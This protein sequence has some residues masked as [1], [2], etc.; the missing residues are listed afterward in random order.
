[1]ESY[2]AILFIVII[3]IVLAYML[4]PSGPK[5]SIEYG[6]FDGE[7]ETLDELPPNPQPAPTPVQNE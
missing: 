1:M 2:V 6:A 5:D 7:L 3:A 4:M